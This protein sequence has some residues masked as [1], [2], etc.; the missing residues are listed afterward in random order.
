MILI[1]DFSISGL[2]ES[3]S[4]S[5][6]RVRHAISHIPTR[7]ERYRK[8]G[9]SALKARTPPTKNFRFRYFWKSHQVQFSVAAPNL[10]SVFINKSLKK[11]YSENIFFGSYLFNASANFT[12]RNISTTNF[13]RFFSLLVYR[14]LMR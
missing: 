6:D 2:L 13:P 1:C 12:K 9:V 11:S 4:N 3:I 14:T 5:Y 8:S 10:K 7:F